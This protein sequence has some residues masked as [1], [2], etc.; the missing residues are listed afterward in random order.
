MRPYFVIT[1]YADVTNG[2]AL[3]DDGTFAEILTG[4]LSDSP[5]WGKRAEIAMEY[6]DV[7]S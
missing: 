1:S 2:H 5:I 7:I 6:C 3:I 4:S